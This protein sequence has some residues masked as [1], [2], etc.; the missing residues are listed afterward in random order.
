MA[1]PGVCVAGYGCWQQDEWVEEK[2]EKGVLE[3]Q[4]EREL[5]EVGECQS[6][7]DRRLSVPSRDSLGG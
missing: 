5:P 7:T 4:R 1:R 6:V 3:Q 2:A